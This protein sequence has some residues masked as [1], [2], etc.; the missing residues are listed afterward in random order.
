MLWGQLG[1]RDTTAKNKI[2]K[3]AD[4]CGSPKN[5]RVQNNLLLAHAYIFV[6]V[7]ISLRRSQMVSVTTYYHLL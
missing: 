1:Y 6:Y 3:N 5:Y 7:S 4:N 2:S